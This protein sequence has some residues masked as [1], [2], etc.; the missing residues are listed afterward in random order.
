MILKTHQ[1]ANICS[2]TL[3]LERR[4]VLLNVRYGDGEGVESHDDKDVGLVEYQD[5]LLLH[6]GRTD[7][8]T[9]ITRVTG[10]RRGA[11]EPRC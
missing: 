3:A 9:S 4:P 6:Q 1:S 5:L 2:P 10:Y 11:A 8:V 7:G